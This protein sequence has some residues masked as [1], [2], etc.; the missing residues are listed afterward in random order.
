[1]Y[2]GRTFGF[3]FEVLTII[4]VTWICG[5]SIL[6]Y[7]SFYRGEDPALFCGHVKEDRD[8]RTRL[9]C[10]DY[11]L[12]YANCKGIIFN[13]NLDHQERCKIVTSDTGKRLNLSQA[14]GAGAFFVKPEMTTACV[15]LGDGV[16]TPSGW[17]S[18]CPA[19]YFPLD[20][21]SD[22]T[23][24]GPQS[25][26]IEFVPGK[27][28]NSFHFPNPGGTTQA[29]FSLGYY[30]ATTYCFPDPERCSKGATFAFWVNILGSTGAFQ[31]IM[32]TI[33]AGGPGF[34]TYWN[35]GG[36]LIA[37]VRRDSDTVEEWKMITSMSF[38]AEHPYGTW[39]HCT[40]TYR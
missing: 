37:V 17:H 39:F 26:V 16:S 32:T 21:H 27:V 35:D 33:I 29:L 13:K 14:D 1:M 25:S 36:G 6:V 15:D 31:G 22:G 9:H 38:L 4:S 11:C 7:K 10:S 3:I 18:G 40:V 19:L 2:L 20:S 28:N 34:L 30:P 23:A 5:H 12:L 24:L 8:A